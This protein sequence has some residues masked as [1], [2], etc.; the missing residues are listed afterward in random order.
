MEDNTPVLKWVLDQLE[1][2]VACIALAVVVL[3]VSWGVITR[4]IT[5]QPAAWASELATLAFA[6]LVFFGASAC[7]KYR[8]HP[9]IDMLVRRLPVSLQTTVRLFNHALL[10]AFF[11]F[12]T[13]FG[14]RFAIDALDNPSPVLRWPLA[15]LYGPVAFCFA[16]MIVRYCQML[17]GKVWHVDAERETQVI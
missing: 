6:W 1:E 3:S 5:A 7:I 2:L 4:Y 10:L 8:L 13:W 15:W 17:S 9:S 11:V 12:M 14:T 16:L